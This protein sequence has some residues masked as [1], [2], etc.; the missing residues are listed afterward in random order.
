M[1]MSHV[2]IMV[3]DMDKAIEFY[4]KALG[5]NIIMGKSKVEEERESAIGRM[6]IA[7][8]GEGFKGFNI[9]HLTT[10]DGIG[11]ELFEMKEREERHVVD[12]SKIG[13]FHFSLETDD[14]EN[15]IE[16]TKEFGG[17]V[18]M[19]IMRYHPEDDSKQQKMV[20]L[21]DPFGNL[22]ELYS[23]SYAETYSSEYE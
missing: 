10:T 18:R 15:V 19:D 8:F 5:L 6:C 7:V 11:F 4:T 1:K 12:F 20:Y 17:K 16:K 9:A 14:F 13:I 3:G 22:F 2:G 23:H 21:E